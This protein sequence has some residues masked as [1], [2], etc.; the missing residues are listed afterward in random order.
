MMLSPHKIPTIA[1]S[2]LCAVVDLVVGC[3]D[4]T[5]WYFQNTKPTAT[6][7]VRR[8]G[9]AIN[10]AFDGFRKIFG[11]THIP[12][13]VDIDGDGDLDLVVGSYNKGPAFFENTGN[14]STPH[15]EVR[16]DFPDNPFFYT[17]VDGTRK[18]LY[19]GPFTAPSFVDIDGG[20]CC[21]V[22]TS[23]TLACLTSCRNMLTHL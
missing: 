17:T 11:S 20:K 4:G 16:P 15:F 9:P 6:A 7:Y 2:P 23:V 8:N 14:L 13:F 10:S 3:A 18:A 22:S 21:P 5:M 19:A 1:I 12:T